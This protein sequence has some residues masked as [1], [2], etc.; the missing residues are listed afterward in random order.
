MREF[1][2]G[3]RRKAG[4]VALIMACVLMVGWF[5]SRLVQDEIR[6]SVCYANLFF[7]SCNSTL[8]WWQL[9]GLDSASPQCFALQWLTHP[10]IRGRMFSFSEL[11]TLEEGSSLTPTHVYVPRE[12]QGAALVNWTVP[13]WS[14]VLPLTLLS[15]YLLLVPSR[16]RPPTESQPHA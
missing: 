5:R 1:F 14:I 12:E 9:S 10:E 4:C 6:I 8:T 2:H 15:A 7:N 16:K 13:Y 11:V 3:W